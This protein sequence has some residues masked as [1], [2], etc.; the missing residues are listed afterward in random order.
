MINTT[1]SVKDGEINID[2]QTESTS[3]E[4]FRIIARNYSTIL[5]KILTKA[6]ENGHD[7]SEYL[8]ELEN[9]VSSGME[10]YL[11]KVERWKAVN[12]EIEQRKKEIE[13][14]NPKS[15]IHPVKSFMDFR[16]GN[17]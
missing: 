1:I 4:E 9:I 15:L 6:L 17:R 2:V 14:T 5:C 13:L 16:I 11:K 8:M 10:D 3:E 12:T 7:N